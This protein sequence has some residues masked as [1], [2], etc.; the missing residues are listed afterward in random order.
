[1][2]K[3]NVFVFDKELKIAR[4]PA[5]LIGTSI[6]SLERARKKA[7]NLTQRISDEIASV[8]RRKT[9]QLAI[10]S[11]ENLS[12]REMAELFA[13]LDSHL[14]VCV[15]FYLGPQLQWSTSTLNEWYVETGMR[16]SE[17]VHKS[18]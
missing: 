2:T 11:A 17:F 4:T 8:A 6:W 14:E 1:M 5:D 9:D 12:I 13:R 15:I 16:F 18:I 3:D 7:E 10:L